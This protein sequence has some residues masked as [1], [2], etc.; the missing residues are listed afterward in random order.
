NNV[1]LKLL[2]IAFMPTM[3]LGAAVTAAVGKAVGERR[4]DIARLVVSW[5]T[6]FG[7][8]YMG[9]VALGYLLFREPLIRALAADEEVVAWAMRLLVI[10]AAFQ[11]FDA[12]Q[13][14]H[15][16]ALRGMADTFWPAVLAATLS[17]SVLL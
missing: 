15:V 7:V 11:I 10:F 13:I 12:I 5:G 1:A 6:R 14:M 2:E 3:G 4:P 8:G 17:F 9:A 16:S